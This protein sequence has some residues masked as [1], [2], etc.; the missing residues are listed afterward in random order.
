M[1]EFNKLNENIDEKENLSNIELEVQHEKILDDYLD[2]IDKTEKRIK[3]PQLIATI[4]FAIY[5][6]FLTIFLSIINPPNYLFTLIPSLIGI[7]SLTLV[8]NLY[9]KLIDIYSEAKGFIETG[10]KQGINVASLISYFTINIV[11][12]GI[13]FYLITVTMKAQ[14]IIMAQMNLLNIPIYIIF[15]VG[16]FYFLFFLPAMIKDGAVWSIILYLL[17]AFSGFSFLILVS[18]I[19][20]QTVEWSYIYAFC[21]IWPAFLTLLIFTISQFCS[22]KE[23]HIFGK[24]SKLIATFLL[25]CFIVV[26]PMK[27]DKYIDIFNWALM[28]FPLTSYM[29][30]F[31]ERIKS[32]FFS[33][34][35]TPEI[36]NDDKV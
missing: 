9:I 5:L 12:I 24:I 32:M 10:K 17:F 2:L 26:L 31:S 18:M 15:G 1:K 25:L 27:L 30:F 33:E 8:M 28:L 19:I 7:V 4:S 29:M 21:S 14:H 34:D 22:G 11:A 16:I 36:Y 35:Q 23:E 6:I 13:I 3:I 20:D